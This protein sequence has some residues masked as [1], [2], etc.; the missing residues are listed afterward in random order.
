M[1]EG[2]L[3]ADDVMSALDRVKMHWFEEH[4]E[5][6]FNLKPKEGIDD[7]EEDKESIA[8]IKSQ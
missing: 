1:K 5:I 2:L 3:Y 4:L 7:H 6:R 8:F